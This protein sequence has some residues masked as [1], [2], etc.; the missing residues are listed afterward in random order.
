M[1]TKITENT[2]KSQKNTHIIIYTTKLGFGVRKPSVIKSFLPGLTPIK[3]TW[4]SHNPGSKIGTLYSLHSLLLSLYSVVC[5]MC[6]PV[7]CRFA[8]A[9]IRNF[10]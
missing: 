2:K 4:Q 9:Q 10:C 8:I 7:V 6:F 3:C 5:N 1:Y